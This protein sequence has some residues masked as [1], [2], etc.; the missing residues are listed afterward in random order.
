MSIRCFACLAK[1]T[2]VKIPNGELSHCAH[3]ACHPPCENL[4]TLLLSKT[5][6]REV[7]LVD[8]GNNIDNDLVFVQDSIDDDR[9]NRGEVRLATYFNQYNN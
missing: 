1:G 8:K 4:A 3:L 5:R 9:N 6:P 2:G 7:T